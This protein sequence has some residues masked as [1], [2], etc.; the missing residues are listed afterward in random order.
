MRDLL[1]VLSDFSAVDQVRAPLWMQEQYQE[2][3]MLA[4]REPD[5]PQNP[6]ATSDVPP[7]VIV[8]LA[9]TLSPEQLE[10]TRD[11]LGPGFVLTD[12]RRAPS[13]AG[14]VVV[15]PCSPGTIR[16]VLRTFPMAQVLV[17][18][19]DAGTSAGLVG[20]ALSGGASWY[21]RSIDGDGLAELVRWA[22]EQV[23]A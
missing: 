18:G 4:T 15:P 19:T 22:H 8:A 3:P 16:A 23:A 17:V 2:S 13:Q 20:R 21:V 11:A 9:V 5:S 10:A 14:V 6:E 12:I 1:T 7:E